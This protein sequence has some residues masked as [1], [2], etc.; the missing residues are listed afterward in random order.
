MLY[1]WYGVLFYSVIATLYYDINNTEY[2]ETGYS[3]SAGIS[4]W[5]I[6]DHLGF[7]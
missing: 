7:L 4:F 1:N 6:Y 5:L 2:F 3:L